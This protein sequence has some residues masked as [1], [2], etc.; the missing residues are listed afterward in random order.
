MKWQLLLAPTLM[1]GMAGCVNIGGW[2]VVRGSGKILA[3]TRPL[4][5][6]EGVSV[7]GAGKLVLVQGSE[8]SVTIEADDNFLPLI[9]SDIAGGRLSLGPKNVNLRSSHTI[10]YTVK[11]RNLNAIHLSGSVDA[12]AAELRAGKLEASISGSGNITIPKL[13]A[14]EVRLR[15]S[16]S[17]DVTFAGKA[18]SQDVGISG[19]GHYE[20][21]NLASQ[22]ALLHIAGAGEV[23]VWVQ[24]SLDS[25]ISGSG[26]VK[27]YGSPRKVSNNVSG[28]GHVRCIGA[29]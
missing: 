24:E 1:L 28:S 4:A 2:N 27:Y 10:R 19:S 17:G 29:K 23:T 18:A 6:F 14:D 3:E 25:W 16:G 5:S 22:H 21:G 9:E 12:E 15:I 8:E 20:A 26:D 7:S 11:C 13:E